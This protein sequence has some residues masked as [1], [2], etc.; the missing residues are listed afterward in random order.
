MGTLNLGNSGTVNL[1]GGAS[2]TGGT[3]GFLAN[4]PSGTI[5][6]T[7]SYYTG[8]GTGASSTSSSGTYY[9]ININGSGQVLRN[10]TKAGDDLL[11]Y[12]K[13]SNDSH[14]HINV[15]FPTYLD[16][17]TNGMGFRVRL[18]VDGGSNYLYIPDNLGVSDTGSDSENSLWASWGLNGY[19]GH[20]A[21]HLSCKYTTDSYTANAD[22]IRTYTGEVRMYFEGRVH[23][24]GGDTAYWISYSNSWRKAGYVY[25]EEVKN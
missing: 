11:A 24:T 25:I 20:T 7:G 2:F 6:K 8:S 16:S 5:I 14:L 21:D 17:G 12:N 9:T 3:S 19:G 1:G 4:A 13:I 10:M 22:T 23:N 15:E 18:S